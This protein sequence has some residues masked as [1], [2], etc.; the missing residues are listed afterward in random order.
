MDMDGPDPGGDGEAAVVAGRRGV[1]STQDR[2]LLC[3]D[4]LSGAVLGVMVT[5]KS[6]C[7]AG[8]GVLAT[9]RL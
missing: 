3:N 9:L 4:F 1:L 6:W 2:L 8:L 5:A 7:L